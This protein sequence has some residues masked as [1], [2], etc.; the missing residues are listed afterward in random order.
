MA[1]PRSA[2]GRAFPVLRG[3]AACLTLC[4]CALA[5]LGGLAVRFGVSE[6]RAAPFYL[7][8]AR[9]LAVV[10]VQSPGG[11]FAVAPIGGP[12]GAALPVE[13]MLPP[14]DHSDYALVM[15]RGLPE[16]FELS[17]G[18][19]LKE[20]WALALN[21]IAGLKLTAPDGFKGSVPL[22]FLFVR[23]RNAA[24]ERAVVE[25]RIAVEP[26]PPPVEAA[27]PAA[28][29]VPRAAA[30][31]TPP[32]I[33]PAVEAALLKRADV[34]LKSNDVAGARLVFEHLANHGSARGAFLMGQSFDPSFFKTIRTSGLKP[35]AAKAR[36]WYQRA[37]S[38]G[39]MEAVSRLSTLATR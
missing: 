7:D 1:G 34:L 26:P 28:P 39:E 36:E 14:G 18:I 22:E 35:D 11:R 23:E 31:A 17:S 12:P 16:G 3:G 38:L 5:L 33:A 13:I 37:A 9:P 32:V 27:R 25:A 21:D 20:S 4:A 8:A 30:E 29:E 19:A 6:T 2:D 15:V 24:P 10:T